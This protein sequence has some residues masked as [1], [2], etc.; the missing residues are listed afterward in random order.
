MTRLTTLP[1]I[2]LAAVVGLTVTM[3]SA[4][5][6]DFRDFRHDQFWAD[7]NS[8][9]FWRRRHHRDRDDRFMRFQEFNQ[10]PPFFFFHRRHHFMW[11]GHEGW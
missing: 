3:S 5:A 7:G 4:S 2:A 6:G 9:D 8:G 11:W 10:L 1:A